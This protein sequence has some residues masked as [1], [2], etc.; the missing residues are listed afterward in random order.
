MIVLKTRFFYIFCIASLLVFLSVPAFC[1][2]EEVNNDEE[3]IDLIESLQASAN[4]TN[5]P[6]THSA[7]I[8]ALD[9][10]TGRILYEKSGYDKTPMAST[11]KILTSIIAIENCNLSDM[12]QISSKSANTSGSTLG[13]QTNDLMTME[14]LLYG[15]MLRSGNDCAV[16]IAEHIGGSIEGFSAIMN[17]KAKALGLTNSNFITPHGLDHD[18]HYTTA[19]ELALLTD[20][21]LKNETFAKIVGTKETVICH[22]T[23]PISNTNELLGNYNGVYGVKTGFTFNAGRCLVTACKRNNLDVI[24][25]VLGADT[26]K[27]RT[28][29]SVKVLNYIYNNYSNINIESVIMQSFSDFELHYSKNSNIKKSMDEPI[30]ELSNLGNT[31]FP[32]TKN[33]LSKLKAETYFLDNLEAPISKQSKIG[34]LTIKLENETLK[35]IDICVKNDIDRKNYKIYYRELLENMFNFL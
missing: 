7:H 26:K 29:D 22:G 19:Y 23:R 18:N 21:A 35:N 25:V 4:T 24:V 16:A 33:E 9:R 31:I 12:V 30:L 28:T 3:T 11:T 1:Y 14:D 20:Y 8:I 6:D 10:N 15:L 27:I 2:D 13:M 17:S 32:L 5:E 34:V